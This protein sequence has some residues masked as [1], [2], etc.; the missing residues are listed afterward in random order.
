MDPS[1]WDEEEAFREALCII[2]EL[3]VV[4][5]RA[6]R[7]V[8]LIQEFNKKLTSGKEQ[9]QFLLQVVSDHRH[10]FPDCSKRTLMAAA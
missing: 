2:N 1:E 6:E 7:G 8:A 5:D 10:K 9:L 3:A 4:N